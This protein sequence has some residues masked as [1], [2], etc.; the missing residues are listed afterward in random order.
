MSIDGAS[1][2]TAERTMPIRLRIDLSYDGTEFFGWAVQPGLRTVQGEL[3][4]AISTVVGDGP[5][6]Q[7]NA[8]SAQVRLTVA[9]RT[10]A[11]V[12]ARGQVAHIDL[13][14]SQLDRWNG[15]NG[16]NPSSRAR[17]VN[18]VLARQKGERSQPGSVAS[19]DLIVR[20]VAI[21]PSG[22]D[23]RFSAIARRYRYRLV[24]T[25]VR[26][27]AL[28]ARD[29]A[30]AHQNLDD[31]ALERMRVAAD[32]LLGL[33][34]FAAFCKARDGATTVRE[35]Q[36]LQVS[37]DD[38]GVINFDIQA[39]AFCHSMVRSVVGA[40]VAVGAGRLSF[41]ELAAIRHEKM[42][43]SRFAVM[44]AHGL[45]LEEILYPPED[46]LATRAEQTRA[47]RT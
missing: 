17:R 30:I 44:P 33:N 41:Q 45:C 6:L 3:E 35:L 31:G 9:G 5:Y 47:R 27:D 7:G 16:D 12:H 21:A 2:E 19:P 25:L 46:E 28:R 26:C 18:G 24:E 32:E 34:D 22:F 11:G 38:T 37:R 15:R 8:G 13:S 42:R 39:D 14:A 40:L 43:S 1:G 20:S 10:D 29:T 23:A 4:R 36:Q